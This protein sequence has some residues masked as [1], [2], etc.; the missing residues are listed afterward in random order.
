MNLVPDNHIRLQ[1]TDQSIANAINK[2]NTNKVI[3]NYASD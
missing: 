3:G 2:S 1:I